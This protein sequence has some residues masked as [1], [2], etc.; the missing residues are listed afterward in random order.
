MLFFTDRCN[1]K[2]LVNSEPE[3]VCSV[4][5]RVN[6]SFLMK[7]FFLQKVYIYLLL[8]FLCSQLLY[9]LLKFFK[10]VYW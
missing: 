8:I 9:K 3:G 6:S 4:N 5:L 2:F 1:T 10:N 7:V